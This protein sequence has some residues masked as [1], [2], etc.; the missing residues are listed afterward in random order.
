MRQVRRFIL[1][2]NNP[3][4]NKTDLYSDMGSF[5]DYVKS[6]E[7]FKYAIFQLEQGE[8][9]HTDHIQMFIIFTCG[10]RLETVKNYFPTAHIEA[11]KGTNV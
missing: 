11:V 3:F 9:E 8:K 6:L 5:T 7:H 10:K 1:T 4:D 2:I